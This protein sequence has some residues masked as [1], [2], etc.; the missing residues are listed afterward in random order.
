MNGNGNGNFVLSEKI[1]GNPYVN[2]GIQGLAGKE[3]VPTGFM[4]RETDATKSVQAVIRGKDSRCQ[5]L[6][7]CHFSQHPPQEE[8]RAQAVLV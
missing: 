3:V 8:L 7:L 1:A 4:V 5:P 2:K 6:H